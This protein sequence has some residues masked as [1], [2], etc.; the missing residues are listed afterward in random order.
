MDVPHTAGGFR[1]V[2]G[3]PPWVPAM[4]IMELSTKKNH[5]AIGVPPWPWKPTPFFGPMN[6]TLIQIN[7][8]MN[9]LH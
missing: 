7:P 5:L 8:Y 6:H 3:V 2:M 9:Q 4:E 1:K